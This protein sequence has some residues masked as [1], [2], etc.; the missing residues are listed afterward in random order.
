VVKKSRARP[1][2]VRLAAVCVLAVSLSACGGAS[3]E[4]VAA[5]YCDLLEERNA[6]LEDGDTE[7]VADILGELAD[8][9]TEARDDDIS[10]RDLADAT[11][12]KC[13]DLQP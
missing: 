8:L 13:P 9:L 6:A 2:A 11:R 1:I 4:D 10:G 3:A 7:E 12:D 5:D